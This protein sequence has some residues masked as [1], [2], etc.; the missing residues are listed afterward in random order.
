[1]STSAKK[2]AGRAPIQGLLEAR[3][4]RARPLQGAP[5]A[6][7]RRQAPPLK[8][9]ARGGEQPVTPRAPPHETPPPARKPRQKTNP[10][11][12]VQMP[13]NRSPPSSLTSHSPPA[14]PRGASAST[15]ARGLQGGS[16]CWALL[17]RAASSGQMLGQDHRRQR[18]RLQRILGDGRRPS[19]ARSTDLEPTVCGEI[20]GHV[21]A[22]HP[23]QIVRRTR[24]TTT[25]AAT[26]V[27]K[28]SWTVLDRIRGQLHGPP[29]PSPSTHGRRHGLRSARSSS[30]ASR[31]TTAR[32]QARS[33]SGRADLRRRRACSCSRRTSSSTRT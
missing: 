19:R 14:T 17:P 8:Y 33:A 23:E 9:W 18:R 21:Q 2:S 6:E 27:G 1:M 7:T 22:R 16:A 11:R 32:N 3:W 24:P 28:E 12:A 10:P 31:S 15:S 25:R 30:S 13:W 26:T 4:P 20:R 5:P 29:G